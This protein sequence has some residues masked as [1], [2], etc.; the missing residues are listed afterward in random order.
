MTYQFRQALMLNHSPAGFHGISL[1]SF[2]RPGAF[3]PAGPADAARIEERLEAAE[4]EVPA[5]PK[6]VGVGVAMGRDRPVGRPRM[7]LGPY[8][9]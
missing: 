3:R 4:W 5:T 6:A 9:E 1:V 8:Y 2:H 7:I